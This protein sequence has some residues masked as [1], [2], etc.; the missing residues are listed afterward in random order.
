MLRRQGAR[1]SSSTRTAASRSWP[2]RWAARTCRSRTAYRPASTR[3]SCRRPPTNVEFLKTWLR[4]LVARHAAHGP[5]GGRSRRSFDGH[6]RARRPGTATVSSDR[7]HRCDAR[8]RHSCAPRALVRE[9][10]RRLRLGVRQRAGLVR[11]ISS[12]R[13]PYSA[14]MSLTFSINALTRA[15]VTLYSSMSFGSSSTAARFVCWMDE[16]WR[17]L[18]DSAFESF[19]KDGRRP[20]GS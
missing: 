6:A 4:A 5:R 3:C 14:S 8:R 10:A 13:R 1:K 12:Q 19:A 15:P 7:V 11:R 9:H 2:E 20:G 18:A 16:F 17:L